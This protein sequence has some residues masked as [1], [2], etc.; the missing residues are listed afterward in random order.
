MSAPSKRTEEIRKRV[1]AK[2]QELA[3]IARDVCDQWPC[4]NS[5]GHAAMAQ[6]ALEIEKQARRAQN[7]LNSGQARRFCDKRAMRSNRLHILRCAEM[8][9]PSGSIDKAR[10]LVAALWRKLVIIARF[11]RVL[12]PWHNSP[13]HIAAAQFEL[14][15]ERAHRASGEKGGRA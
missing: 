10:A 7:E 5:P 8:S 13:G 11:V 15:V 9:T 2:W 12:W 1:A 3:G 4:R 6:F 14:E